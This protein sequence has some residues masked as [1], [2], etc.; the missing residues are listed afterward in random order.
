MVCGCMKSSTQPYRAGHGPGIAALYLPIDHT[1]L[2]W[3]SAGLSRHGRTCQACV[4]P[5]IL[6]KE[7]EHIT[8]AMGQL[9]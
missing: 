6:T 5:A 2:A 9:P 1:N 4:W 3:T 7:P 8:Q